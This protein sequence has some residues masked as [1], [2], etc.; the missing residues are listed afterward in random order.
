VTVL[1]L[2]PGYVAAGEWL[3]ARAGLSELV[4]FVCGDALAAPL[5][6]DH[7]VVLTQHSTMNIPDKPRLFARLRDALA[8]RGCYLFHEIVAGD[9]EVIWPVPWAASGATSF[10]QQGDVM[11]RD[12]EAAGFR[13]EHFEDVS[14]ATVAW[15]RSRPQGEPPPLGLHVLC[16]PEFRTLF[17]NLTTNLADG[18]VRVVRGRARR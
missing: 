18:R 15:A 17:A 3:T 4:E 8:P 11:Q 9:G 10:L 6:A 12:L 13:L 14:A 5:P 16:G 2:T 7:D 1:D